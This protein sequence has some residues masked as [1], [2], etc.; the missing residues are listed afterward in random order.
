[1]SEL[2]EQRRGCILAFYC[3]MFTRWR[4]EQK[5]IE[6]GKRCSSVLD[7]QRERRYWWGQRF[8]GEKILL[9]LACLDCSGQVL[10]LESEMQFSCHGGG[11]IGTGAGKEEEEER[12]ENGCVH[13]SC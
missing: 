9:V 1:M 12:R 6:I 7:V 2:I 8:K 5:E 10:H 13:L 11:S 3:F 4:K